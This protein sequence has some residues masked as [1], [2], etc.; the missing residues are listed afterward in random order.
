M[1]LALNPNC[2]ETLTVIHENIVLTHSYI[3]NSINHV[4]NLVLT[5]HS[6]NSISWTVSCSDSLV[7]ATDIP[8]CISTTLLYKALEKLPS[9]KIY[10]EVTES[11]CK[12]LCLHF[13]DILCTILIYF[14]DLRKCVMIPRIVIEIKPQNISCDTALIFERKRC[15]GL[16]TF[17]SDLQL[18]FSSYMIIIFIE[19][20]I[21]Y[22]LEKYDN[23][24]PSLDKN[25]FFCD[26]EDDGE[27][28]FNIDVG[29]DELWRVVKAAL[30]KR[31]VVNALPNSR[32]SRNLEDGRD[33]STD[34]GKYL[35]F[36]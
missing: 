8:R 24:F 15:T 1:F 9:K 11:G 35:I 13:D 31:K 27:C 36:Q 25:R 17:F 34:S 2:N 12:E 20:Y 33:H 3:S 26:F 22:W 16:F 10:A 5:Q 29:G 14:P 28:D 32:S 7:H 18:S 30:Y 6:I 4:S 21:A 19:F 23:C